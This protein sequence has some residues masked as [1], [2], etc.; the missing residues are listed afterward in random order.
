MIIKVV[1]I[2]DGGV[3]KTS[4]ARAYL[5]KEFQYEYMPTIGVDFY[6]KR[7]KVHAETLGEIMITWH[8][9]D[10]SGQP[11]WKE[12]R[13]VFYEGSQG[14]LLVFDI[15]N[16]N[17]YRDTLTWA[18]EFVRNAGKRPII[19][20]GNKIDLRGK[21][22]KCL[23]YGD[24][25]RMAK[26]ISENFNV[27]VSYVETSALLRVNIDKAFTELARSIFKCLSVMEIYL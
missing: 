3:G 1:L 25:L 5:R 13:P 20:I 24:G 14:A 6:K 9:W 22:D 17:S 7:I 8:I 10:F 2:G 4:I 27:D 21:V 12:V 26:N 15:S 19:L 23:T 18:G 11:Y 16:L